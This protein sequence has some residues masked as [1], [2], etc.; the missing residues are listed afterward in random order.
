MLFRSGADHFS[1]P[2]FN[3]FEVVGDLAVEAGGNCPLSKV[4]E[5][6]KHNSVKIVGYANVPGRVANGA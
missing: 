3:G 4:G 6:V 1:P 5:V 2:N